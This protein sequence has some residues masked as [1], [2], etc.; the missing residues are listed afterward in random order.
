MDPK[1][2]WLLA[3]LTYKCP[4]QCPYCSNPLDFAGPRFKRELSTD[5]WCRVF[6]EAKALGVLQLGL[7]GGE[8][9]L[10]PDLEQLVRTA[11]GLGL[12]TSLITSA[13]RLTRERLAPPRD[14]ARDR[15]G[16]PRLPRAVPQAVHGRLGARLHD[17]HAG[18]RG[19]A[20]SCG[21]PDHHVDLRERAG[22]PARLDLGA[23]RRVQPVPRRRLDARAVPLVPAQGAGFRRGPLPGPPGRGRRGRY[24]SGVLPLPPAPSDRRPAPGRAR[25]R[26]GDPPRGAAV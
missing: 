23:L 15:V 8:P 9:T 25:T 11:H 10:R 19:V 16:P 13:F 5:E 12:Y 3:E 4:L 20:L 1:P 18:G 17:R 7:S 14:E 26:G 6:R 22:P 2:L 21:G 24:G